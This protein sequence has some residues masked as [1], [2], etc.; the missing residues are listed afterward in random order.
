MRYNFAGSIV[1]VSLFFVLGFNLSE[2]KLGTG[3]SANKTTS[4]NL[5]VK[6]H[7]LVSFESLP[8]FPWGA[9]APVLTVGGERWVRS[10]LACGSHTFCPSPLTSP[11]S[12]HKTKYAGGTRKA[13]PRSCLPKSRPWL[14][15]SPTPIRPRQLAG[16]GQPQVTAAAHGN[17]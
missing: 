8:L 13:S 2:N 5:S 16:T 11:L 6:E 4:V 17:H 15:G 3:F 9:R 10:R 14:Q 7:A 1:N 12:K